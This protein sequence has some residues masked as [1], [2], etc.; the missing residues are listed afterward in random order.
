MASKATWR[1][2]DHSGEMSSFSVPGVN[3][4]AANLVAQQALIAALQAAM[5][6]IIIGVVAEETVLLSRTII[7]SALPASGAAQRESKWLVT[8]SDLVTG[9]LHQ[10]EIPCFDFSN[11]AGNT[12]NLDVSPGSQGEDFVT[13]FEAFVRAEGVNA[14]NVDSVRFVGRNL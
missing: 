13:A 1:I 4:S 11:L 12:E 6:N 5:A 8:Y 10:A 3:L 7:S 2:R 14:V 9:G